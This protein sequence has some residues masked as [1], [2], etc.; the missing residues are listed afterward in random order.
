MGNVYNSKGSF[1]FLFF[2]NRC[3]QICSSLIANIN[4]TATNLPAS[5]VEDQE[6]E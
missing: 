6:V 5:I 2:Y 4:E 3:W 1:N